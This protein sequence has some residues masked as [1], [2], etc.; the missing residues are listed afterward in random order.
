MEYL[1]LHYK[2]FYDACIIAIK[3]WSK[4]DAVAF[5]VQPPPHK[6]N[7]SMSGKGLLKSKYSDFFFSIEGIIFYIIRVDIHCT[8]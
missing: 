5:T 6:K 3:K 7:A 8:I 4:C 2:R 1:I